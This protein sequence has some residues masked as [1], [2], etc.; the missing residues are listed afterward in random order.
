MILVLIAEAWEQNLAIAICDS[1]IE[2]ME[3][4][5]CLFAT[6]ISLRTFALHDP[7]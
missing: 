6:L 7:I 4:L 5:C 1:K 3:R 2:R